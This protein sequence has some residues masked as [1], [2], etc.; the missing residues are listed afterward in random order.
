MA[1]VSSDAAGLRPT[2]AS[3]FDWIVAQVFACMEGEG[4][5]SMAKGLKLEEKVLREAEIRPGASYQ[6]V[7]T[8]VSGF[9]ARVQASFSRTFTIDN[10]HVGRKRR[11]MIGCWL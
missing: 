3:G 10:R 5:I 1:I 4:V 6:I 9:A 2:A 11:K 8:D 7:D